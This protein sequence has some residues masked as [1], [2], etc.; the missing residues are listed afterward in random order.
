MEARIIALLTDF[1]A[2]DPYVGVVKG[3][4]LGINPQARIVDLAHNL[5]K[6]NIRAAAF[7]LLITYRYFPKNTVFC[8][9]V[10][11]GVGTKRKPIAIKTDNY[12]FVGPDNGCLVWAAEKDGIQKIIE[13]TNRSYMLDKVSTTFHGRDIFAP[14]AAHIS[15]G[16]DIVSLG[17]EISKE[18]IT[19]MEF[20]QPVKK[21]GSYILEMI[22]CDGFGN[23]ILNMPTSEADFKYGE[24]VRI[25]VRNKTY[26]ARVVNTYGEAP[27]GS[28]LLLRQTSHGYV[29]IAVNKGSAKQLLNIRQGEKIV[30]LEGI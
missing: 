24:K 9:V 1:S 17:K 30:I 23:I 2:S 19:R 7:Y 21:E 27:E 6:Y 26:T 22:V 18:S 13:I 16:I 5:P 29:E 25:L 20:P 10:D 14:A 11:P 28:L 3:V 15:R 12:Y 4:I 8:C